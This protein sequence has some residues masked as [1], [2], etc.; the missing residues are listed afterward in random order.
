MEKRMKSKYRESEL[1]LVHRF[2]EAWLAEA[3]NLFRPWFADAGHHLPKVSALIG[4]TTYGDRILKRPL[5]GQCLARGWSVDGNTN[6]VIISPFVENGIHA[7]DVLGHE[8]IHAVDNCEHRHGKEF[9]EIAHSV[10]HPDAKEGTLRDM[11]AWF[12]F[13]GD[14]MMQ[15]GRYPGSSLKAWR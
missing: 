15:L 11:K 14:L 8:L 3:V 10:R 9:Y 5:L 2:G 1:P 13:T 12:D 4:F 6:N 7:L